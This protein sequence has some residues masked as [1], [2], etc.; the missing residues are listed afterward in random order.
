MTVVLFCVASLGLV[1][2]LIMLLPLEIYEARTISLGVKRKNALLGACQE[3]FVIKSVSSAGNLEFEL[4]RVRP[5]T[6]EGTVR[7]RVLM[8]QLGNAI[9]QD[10]ETMFYTLLERSSADRLEAVVDDKG[11]VIAIKLVADGTMQMSINDD[12]NL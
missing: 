12:W 6:M 3:V 10:N 1:L 7:D 9:H 5:D 2:A 8:A 11:T 4:Y